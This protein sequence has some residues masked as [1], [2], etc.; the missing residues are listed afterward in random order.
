MSRKRCCQASTSHTGLAVDRASEPDV[1]RLTDH[2]ELDLGALVGEAISLNEPIAPLCEAACP[3][4]CVTCGER[5]GPGH[6]AHEDEALDPGWR[7]SRPSGSTANRGAS[8]LRPRPVAAGVARPRTH[9]APTRLA[10]DLRQDTERS[11]THPW[12]CR[13]ARSP[14]LGRGIGARTWRSTLPQ[15]EE[16]PHCHQP[17]RSHRACPNCGYYGGRPVLEI[18]AAKDESAPS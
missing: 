2:H 17:K 7:R 6:V 4:L 8:R 18:K 9:S 11:S 13:S 16:C 3:G 5:L 14:T 1:A 12:A 15:L 10:I